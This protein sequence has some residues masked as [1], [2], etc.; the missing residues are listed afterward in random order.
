MKIKWQKK[1]YTISVNRAGVIRQSRQS[2]AFITVVNLAAQKIATTICYKNNIPI[3]YM[4][5]LAQEFFF[6]FLNKIMP[7]AGD[8]KCALSTYFYRA[9][10]NYATGLYRSHKRARSFGVSHTE[11]LQADYKKWDKL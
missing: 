5:D 8:I 6:I 1:V 9:C 10:Q 4:P 7:K 3:S 11:V 2:Y